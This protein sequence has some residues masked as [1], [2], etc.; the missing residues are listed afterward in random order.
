MLP[1][2]KN[3][4]FYRKK[5]CTLYGA[6]ISDPENTTCLKHVPFYKKRFRTFVVATSILALLTIGIVLLIN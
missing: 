3:C 6:M 2:C 1:N 5:K 4:Q